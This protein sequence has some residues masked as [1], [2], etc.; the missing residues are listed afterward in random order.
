MET[1][2]TEAA[3]APNPRMN[4][5]AAPQT[6][7]KVSG[8]RRLNLYIAGEGS[9]TVIL[10]PGMGGT[11]L[12]WGRVQ[13]HV[14]AFTRTVSFDHAGMGFSDPGPLPR[15]SAAIVADLHA[16]L[17]AAGIAPP[18]VIAGHSAGGMHMRLFAFL[19]PDEV[20]GMV[21]VDSSS[22]HQG[23]RLF[24]GKGGRRRER[25]NAERLAR[26]A[27]QARAGT[28]TPDSPDYAT[29]VGEPDPTLTPE[30]NAAVRAQHTSSAYWRAL[31]SESAAFGAASSEQ[32][33]AAQRSLGDMPLI[34][35]TA[36]KLALS[37]TESATP[38]QLAAWTT[39]HDEIAALSSRGVRRTIE[40][41]HNIQVEQPRA[42]IEA[43]EE[44]VRMVR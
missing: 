8:R 12:S 41:G 21:M 10:A 40:C 24:E 6:L 31:S 29:A 42:V 25:E 27:S 17:K 35:L 23:P 4:V 1:Q 11:T 39:M 5:Y 7:V 16:A 36:G 18:Y 20:V 2:M 19:Y 34:V 28:L 43:I 13:R 22:A 32:L 3:A 37:A 38:A 26:V 15:T 9:P 30:L 14:A 33:T 44:V